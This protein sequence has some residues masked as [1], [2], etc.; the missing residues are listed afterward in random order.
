MVLGR[1]R[2]AK[3]SRRSPIQFR[4]PSDPRACSE[5]LAFCTMTAIMPPMLSTSKSCTHSRNA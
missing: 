2:C 4:M 3:Y 1:L 5:F